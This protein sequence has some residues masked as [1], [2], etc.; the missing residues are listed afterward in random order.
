MT[1]RALLVVAVALIVVGVTGTTLIG[2]FH[3]I[4]ESRPHPDLH[5]RMEPREVAEADGEA[6]YRASCASCHGVA[7]RGGLAPSLRR[8][9]AAAMT[10][11]ELVEVIRD[12]RP[13]RGMPA[14]GGV[15]S[16]RQIRAVAGYVRELSHS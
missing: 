16:D 7:G 14:W 13:R 1:R 5:L 10:P 3:P 4:F 11:D 2:D 15:L 8:G 9:D 12:G 6:I